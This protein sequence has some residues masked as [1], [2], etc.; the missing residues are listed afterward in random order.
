M[1]L[2]ETKLSGLG[3]L[4][5][6]TTTPHTYTRPWDTLTALARRARH[7]LPTRTQ[8]HNYLSIG[9]Y[10][11]PCNALAPKCKGST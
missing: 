8:R 7:R 6:L 11:H 4:V 9:I 1:H 3:V 5:Q 2:A 10:N